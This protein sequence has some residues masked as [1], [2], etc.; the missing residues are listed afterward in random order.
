MYTS[1]LGQADMEGQTY[2]AISRAV[3]LETLEIRGFSSN[4][5]VPL[6]T[7]HFAGH[8]ADKVG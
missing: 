2:V 7:F 5:Q 8:M 4:K 1:C 3:S 6:C